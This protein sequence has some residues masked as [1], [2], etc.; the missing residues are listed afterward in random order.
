[1]KKMSG[2][3]GVC[4]C[5]CVWAFVFR[6]YYDSG[7]RSGALRQ[8]LALAFIEIEIKQSSFTWEYTYG[9]SQMCVNYCSWSFENK[10]R[11]RTD[12]HTHTELS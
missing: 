2:R 12:T 1:M 9:V 10:C 7:I 8:H 3:Q 11:Y 5:V 4:E 6:R